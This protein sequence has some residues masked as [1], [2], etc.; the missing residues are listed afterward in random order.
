MG[1]LSLVKMFAE[2]YRSRFFFLKCR[3]L[4]W[5]NLRCLLGFTV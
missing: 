3:L 2:V 1:K 5:I 4:E